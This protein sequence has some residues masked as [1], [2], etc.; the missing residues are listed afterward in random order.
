M[1]S[2]K[3][4]AQFYRGGALSHLGD[5]GG[6]GRFGDRRDDRSFEGNYRDR[7]RSGYGVEREEFRGSFGNQGSGG[8]GSY[9]R[10][11]DDRQRYEERQHDDYP[12]FNPNKR[13][14]DER[15]RLEREEQDLRAKLRRE[16]EERNFGQ[17]ENR[18]KEEGGE[19]KNKGKAGFAPV[20]NHCFNCNLSGHFRKDCTNPPFCYCCKKSGHRSSVCP[21]KRGLRLCGFGMP[22]QGFYSIHLPTDKEERKSKECLGIMTI[23]YGYADVAIIERELNHLFKEVPRWNINKLEADNEFLITFPSEDIR[24]QVAKFKG[25]DFETSIIKASVV[26]TE[27]QAEVDG[28]LEVVWVKAYNLPSSAR[29]V[30]VVM[31]I[32]YLVGD[33]EEVDLNSLSANGPVRVKIACRSAKELRGETQIFFNGVSRRIRWVV[34]QEKTQI[35]KDPT[36]SKFD[37]KRNREEEDEEEEGDREID[38]NRQNDHTDKAS[39]GDKQD[40]EIKLPEQD[41]GE[42]PEKDWEQAVQRSSEEMV[43]SD[44]E[45]EEEELID[46]DED[47]MYLEKLEMEKLEKSV[48][49][50]AAK[51]TKDKQVVLPTIQT[52][53]EDKDLEGVATIECDLEGSKLNMNEVYGTNE[54]DGF[55]PVRIKKAPVVEQRKSARIAR[56]SKGSTQ[57]NAEAI[58]KKKN[59]ISCNISSFAVFNTFNSDDLKH[60]AAISNIDLGD[61]AEKVEATINSL[62]AHELAQATLL[63]A[64]QKAV[65]TPN[66]LKES[67]KTINIEG[68]GNDSLEEAADR[69]D[70][71]EESIE[72]VSYPPP[73]K[74]PLKRTVNNKAKSVTANSRKSKSRK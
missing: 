24:W 43:M 73:K 27:R 53:A 45:E 64:K 74:P 20:E 26:P 17:R 47:P 57:G 36:P 9:G 60:F 70:Q 28:N 56:N 1:D 22:G 38:E 41:S 33:P 30:E 37:R 18:N 15:D 3:G 21:E 42:V 19:S 63:A 69:E 12:A 71:E 23:E 55:T 35:T 62:Q 59:E 50:R 8:T 29:K 67:E 5:R 49:E 48:E 51:L 11:Y 14:T 44:N 68:A 52:G 72:L 31:E 66:H 65:A 39:L 2:N 16:Q 4:G 58:K 34:E 10:G 54:G 61:T 32:A 25:F 40:T 13:Q 46:Y 7:G 6:P